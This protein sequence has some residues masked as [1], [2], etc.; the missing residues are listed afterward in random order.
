MLNKGKLRP[1]SLPV[2]DYSPAVAKAVE[3]LGDRYVLAKPIRKSSKSPIRGT[4]GV[5]HPPQYLWQSTTSFQERYRKTLT[6]SLLSYSDVSQWRTST[7]NELTHR[8]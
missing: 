1:N 7:A 8:P 4:L 6:R 3:W 5:A 2:A